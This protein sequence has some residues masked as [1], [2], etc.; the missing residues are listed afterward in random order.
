MLSQN[1]STG[2]LTVAEKEKWI[3]IRREG[4]G[5]LHELTL[6]LSSYL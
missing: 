3:W 4:L 6:T 2:H 1:A 5:V